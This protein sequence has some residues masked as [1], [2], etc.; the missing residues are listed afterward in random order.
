[1]GD[2]RGNVTLYSNG[3]DKPYW[4][5]KSGGSHIAYPGSRRRHYLPSSHDNFV[6]F[7]NERNGDVVWKKRMAAAIAS[8]ADQSNRYFMLSGH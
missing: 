1:M 5:F 3:S 8:I 4:R 7:L 6:Y 2:E